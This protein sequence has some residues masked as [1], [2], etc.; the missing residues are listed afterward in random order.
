M[1]F[2]NEIQL[3]YPNAI[4]LGSGRPDEKYFDLED[5][6]AYFDT[7]VDSI[8]QMQKKGSG[9]GHKQPRPI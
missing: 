2:L 4:S 7:Y 6:K 1:G 5:F 8:C 9:G 3:Q